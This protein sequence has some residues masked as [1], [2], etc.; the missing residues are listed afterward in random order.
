MGYPFLFFQAHYGMQLFTTHPHSLSFR[1]LDIVSVSILKHD[2]P[3]C[4]PIRS[5]PLKSKQVIIR[6][7]Y[8][9]VLHWG[10][11]KHDVMTHDIG[12]DCESD[13]ENTKQKTN[14]KRSYILLTSFSI[15]NDKHTE[16]DGE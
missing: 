7:H 16:Q 3:A 12:T 5:L 11:A 15:N 6:L 14:Q 2:Q 13:N 9:T 10:N 4:F 8:S 1:E